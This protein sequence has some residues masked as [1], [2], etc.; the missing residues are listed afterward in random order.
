MAGTGSELCSVMQCGINFTGLSLQLVT[1]VCYGKQLRFSNGRS[2]PSSKAP[3]L[4]GRQT[5]LNNLRKLF[6]FLY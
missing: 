2:G 6:A 3:N 1:Q 5:K 4:R